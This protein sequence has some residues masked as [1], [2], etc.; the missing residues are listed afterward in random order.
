MSRHSDEPE[1]LEVLKNSI[2][3]LAIRI[4]PRGAVLIV[5]VALSPTLLQAYKYA[6]KPVESFWSG[7]KIA[8]TLVYG[9]HFALLQLVPL[10][11][12]TARCPSSVEQANE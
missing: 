6:T 4:Q 11:V 2:Q 10:W 3:H 7:R 8:T 12:K 5:A 9:T 1:K